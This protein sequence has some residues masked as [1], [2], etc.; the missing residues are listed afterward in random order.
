MTT[1]KIRV[2]V[3]DDSALVRK[4]ITDTLQL[5]PEIEVVGVANDPLIAIDKI[6]KLQPDVLTL[7]M[8]MPRMDGL[9][10][11]RQL[12]SEQSTLPVVVISSLTQQGSQLALEA[13]E[14]GAQEV[15][16]KPDGHSSIG[17]LASK[18]AFH[19]KA[20]HRARRPDR[21]R[22]L[23]RQK[24]TFAAQPQQPGPG[25]RRLILI[26]ASTGGVE[27][28]RYL[29]PA[30]PAQ[31][32]PILVVQHIPAYFSKAVADR[33]NLLT[34]YEVREACDGDLLRPGLCLIAPG[35]FHLMVVKENGYRVRLL[36][37]PPVHHCRP[38]VD[39]MFRSAAAAAG[40]H[41]LAVLLTGMGS[42]G[43]VGMQAIQRA[44]GHTLAEAEES[45]VIYGMPRA[46][47]ELNAVDRSIPLDG[48]PQAIIDGLSRLQP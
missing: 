5:D 17:A 9:T 11:L 34:P 24:P 29:L 21:S 46:A 32:P 48:M 37:T 27:A 8:E 16:A 20:A 2:L 25:D 36:Q 22:L 42:D 3:I 12:R 19:I 26:G 38:S 31:L 40:S 1:R 6:P 14:A 23:A 30:L 43:A 47:V 28:L 18:L 4:T 13:L 15:L 45:C 7:D 10:F 33:L 39:V 44:G 41:A 35:D